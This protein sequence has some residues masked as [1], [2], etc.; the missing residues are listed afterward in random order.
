MRR[1]HDDRQREYV[2]QPLPHLDLRRVL[3]RPANSLKTDVGTSVF[4]ASDM[5][6]CLESVPF[7][8]APALRF[9]DYYNTTLQFQ[10]TLA[11]LKSP[12]AGYQQPAVDVVGVMDRI[13]ANVTAGYYTTQYQFEQEVQGLVFAIHDFHTELRSGIMAPIWFG[14]GSSYSISA[15]S[16]DGKEAPKIYFT[17]KSHTLLDCHRNLGHSSGACQPTPC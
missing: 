17:R 9:L 16:L 12:P 5:D 7:V 2:S 6:A 4:Y 14:S 13:K 15:A 10:S 8:A 1:D 11:F 3:V